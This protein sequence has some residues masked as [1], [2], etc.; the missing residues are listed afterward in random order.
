MSSTNVFS[1]SWHKI[2]GLRVCLLNSISI[3]KQVN[4]A[5]EIYVLKEP[6][7][8][9]Y[10]KITKEAY[11]FVT[12]LNLDKTV[13][14]VTDELMDEKLED[15]PNQNEII[16][17]LSSLHSEN[18]LFFKN[19][20]ENDFIFERHKEKKFK[21]KKSKIYSFLFFK[22]P[23]LNPNQLL[24]KSTFLINI[25]FNKYGLI[26]WLI[27]C[28][29]GL[30]AAV[31]NIEPIF[32]QAQGMLSPKNIILLY[33]SLALMKL[34]HEL[35]HSA[36]IKKYGG[37]VN[38]LG[39]MFLVLTPLPYM[40]ATHC[41]FFRSKYQ[42]ILVSFAGMMSDLFFAAIATI[43]WSNTGDGI[44]HSIAF[45]VMIIGSVSSLLFNGN[46][47]LRF[48]A[49]YMLADYLEIPN[50]FQ[51]SK[52]YF[53]YICEKYLFNVD[54]QANPSSSIQES[55]WLLTYAIISY[56]Y[57]II[58]AL[59]I[60]IYVADQLFIVGVLMA[61]MT[62]VIWVFTPL[63][64][65]IIYLSNSQKLYKT[66]SR[67]LIIS[68]S[69][70]FI[71]LY[72]I[73]FIPIANSIKAP[74]VIEAK[75]SIKIYA[76]TEGVVSKIFLKNGDIVKEGDTIAILE[77]MDLEFD[78]KSLKVSLEQVKVIRQKFLSQ[79]SIDLKSLNEKEDVLLEKL[80]YLEKKKETL[81]IKAQDSGIFV[82]NSF[83]NLL[84]SFIKRQTLLGTIVKGN[85]LN[86]FAV[87]TQEEAY[88][89]FEKKEILNSSVKF[90]GQS[91]KAI[92]LENIS[93]IPYARDELPSA[94]LGWFGGGDI[95]V[96][97]EDSNGMKTNE[98]FFEITGIFKSDEKY[99]KILKEGRTGILKIELEKAS[100]SQQIYTK[101]NQI[102]QKRY[103]I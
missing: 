18:L 90:F 39:I 17:L 35:A 96:S 3:Q 37:S 76:K 102:L 21:E 43:I 70:I 97:S 88:E 100:I 51:K 101:V 7:N 64:K 65:F 20:P 50:L 52:D 40:D 22:V 99:K 32:D 41:W 26:F 98:L 13:Q 45:N 14:E 48:D 5:E 47:L 83:D 9:K 11:K 1:D 84:H 53:F 92:S 87:I 59:G 77:N 67:A 62:A 33:I 38:T 69:L 49:Y 89:L 2:S 25:I 75:D 54:N 57:R 72:C 56:L 46:P 4:R 60:I 19:L 31:D 12:R 71:L 29:F 68:S 91:E 55:F 10:F 73:F 95:S 30:K 44:V 34:F 94:A 81:T 6:Y 82:G 103:K 61:I 27:V 74:G 24:D 78:I 36:V 85:D 93:L 86:F 66:R 16:E 8:N 23:L 15:A 58:I 63:K 79:S 42:R 80:K 28:A